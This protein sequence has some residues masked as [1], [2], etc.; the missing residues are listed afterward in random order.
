MTAGLHADATAHPD[1]AG[2]PRT[3]AGA[4][5]LGVRRAPEDP[6][7]RDAAQLRPG[8]PHRQRHGARPHRGAGAAHAAPQGRLLG[9]ARRPLRAED[10]TL[11]A[12][13]LREATEESGI[14]GLRLLGDAPVDLDRHALSTAFGTCG[15]HLDVR[16]AVVAPP[17]AEPVVSE[18]SDDVRSGRQFPAGELPRRRGGA[19]SRR[20]VQRAHAAGAW[21]GRGSVVGEVEPGRRRHALE[22]APGPLGARERAR[23]GPRSP[24]RARAPAGARARAPAR[25]RPP[26]TASPAAGGQPD[27]AVDR[28]ARAPAAA[29]VAHPAHAG[30]PGPA[31]QPGAGTA[32]WPGPAAPV[33]GA[34]L[35]VLLGQPL[36][37]HGHPSP[38][39]G[40]AH[41]GRDQHHGAVAVAVGGHGPAPARR[42]PY[43]DLGGVGRRPPGTATPAAPRCDSPQ[44]RYRLSAVHSRWTTF[45]QVNGGSVDHPQALSTGWSAGSPPRLGGPVPRSSPGGSTAAAVEALT[46]PRRAPSVLPDEAPGRCGRPARKGKAIGP[47]ARSGGFVTPPSRGS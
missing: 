36:E 15:E 31:G 8:A 19:T 44:K 29:L 24:A 21:P 25:S 45:P 40:P 13:A 5:A 47:G 12:A 16:Y 7:R 2:P 14:D 26:R 20:L 23:P 42:P 32:R 22:V 33:A 30:R 1:R 28:G 46:G 6:R 34:Q 11:A 41:P 10:D 27:G 4:A 18:E 43:L 39:L 35:A 17:G 9:P 38:L 37:H 3:P